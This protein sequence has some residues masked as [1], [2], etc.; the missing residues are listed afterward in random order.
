MTVID[1]PDPAPFGGQVVVETEAI[2]V[3]GVDAMIRRGTLGGYGFS[4]G[5]VPGSEVAGT[6]VR[7]GDGVDQ[8]WIGRRVWAFTGV[9][10]GYAEQA[11]AAV[12]DTLALPDD[13]SSV[14][15]VTLGSAGARSR[16]SPSRTA[17]SPPASRSSSVGRR[18]A[19]G[20]PPSSS[21]CAA[22]PAS[23]P[24]RRRRIERGSRLRELGATHVL[25]RAG[26][27]R[28]DGAGDLRRDHRHR[29]RARHAGL[30]RPARA[31]GRLVAVGWSQDS[32]RRTSACA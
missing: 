14:D 7:V 25:D 18:A 1:V 4:A 17:G 21:P 8:A 31:N 12:A 28:P 24:S 29:R 9:G 16:T 27:G 13:L 32:R 11:V 3:G 26:K 5:M 2:G 22:A 15:A 6:V 19:S 30:P 23:W 20:S 10:G